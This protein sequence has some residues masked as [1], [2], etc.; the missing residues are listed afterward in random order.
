M[1]NMKNTLN[2]P[3]GGVGS[4]SGTQSLSLARETKR[5]VRIEPNFVVWEASTLLT[6]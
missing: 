1:H 2:S 6:V 5:S 3:W 4:N